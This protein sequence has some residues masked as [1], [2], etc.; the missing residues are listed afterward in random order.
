MQWIN[1]LIDKSKVHE[2]ILP[3]YNDSTVKLFV[4]R[5]DLIHSEI[6]GNKLRKLKYNLK[7]L[8][9]NNCSGLI[10]Y[11]GAY[12]NHLLA[13]ASA[14]HI[15]KIKSIGIVRGEE[16]NENSN[17]ILKKC[18]SLG[19]KLQF[20][21]RANFSEIKNKSGVFDYEGKNYWFVPEGGANSEG[22]RGSMEIVENEEFDLVCLAQGTTTTSLGVLLSLKINQQ[23]LVVPV[24]K[25]FNSKKEMQNLLGDNRLFDSI[26]KKVIVSD[27][28]H[29][30]GYAK[31]NLELN[32]F[33]SE[34]NKFNNFSIEPIY[35]GKAMFALMDYLNSNKNMSN[36]KVLFVHTGGLFINSY[37]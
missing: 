17:Y 20:V 4:K 2:F 23:I 8:I 31:T 9:E 14:C 7:A 36:K 22:Y 32:D 18:V 28:F 25:G 11:G 12:S 15:A 10:T 29:F 24:L 33:V 37:H 6:S 1:D 30:G 13:T 16:L 26:Q 5:D 27:E 35:T 21:S 19:M 34:F 3:N